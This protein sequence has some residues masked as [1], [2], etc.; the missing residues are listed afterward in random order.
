MLAVMPLSL[1]LLAQTGNGAI[2]G[3]AQD[4]AGSALIGARVV[5]QPTGR[6]T[7]S[8]NQGN[9]RISDLPAGQY[10]I[11]ASYVG[12][13]AYTPRSRSLRTDSKRNRRAPGR[14]KR[15]FGHRHRRAPSRRC[16]SHQCGAY[17]GPNRAGGAQGVIQSLP[18]TNIADA[19]GRLPSVSLERDEGEGKYVQISWYRSQG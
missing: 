1:P 11:T 2:A 4:S 12:F 5:V 19:I 18:N 10:T 17:V 13:T 6:E 16:G 3:T 7:A 8:D 15:R 9:F 14:F